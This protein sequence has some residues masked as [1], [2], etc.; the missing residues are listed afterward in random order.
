M[1]FAS[2][3]ALFGALA[4]IA[5]FLAAVA[6]PHE[7]FDYFGRRHTEL[8]LF[9]LNAVTVALPMAGI[10]FVWCLG[11]MRLL[12]SPSIAMAVLCLI[13]YLLGLGYSFVE[14]TMNFLAI[15]AQGKVPFSVALR[16]AF[17]WWNTPMF[18]AVPLGILAAA[19]LRVRSVRS[20][21]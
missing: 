14:A 21:Q 20:V 10:A 16:S 9:L 19:T 5:G 12:R 8:A 17:T 18:V 7:Y 3:V 4:P 13:G 2:G 11:T 6:I 1:A 15:E